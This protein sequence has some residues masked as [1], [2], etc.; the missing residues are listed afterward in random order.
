M[1]IEDRDCQIGA[2]VRAYSQAK[3]ELAHSEESLRSMAENYR[4]TASA[5]DVHKGEKFATSQ[6]VLSE[7]GYPILNSEQLAGLLHGHEIKKKNVSDTLARIR[8]FGMNIE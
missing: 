8:G 3:T 7:A 1:S 2:A 4:K 5:L 6:A